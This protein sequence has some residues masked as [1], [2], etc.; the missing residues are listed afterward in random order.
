MKKLN[1]RIVI[2]IIL[3]FC[4]ISF[5]NVLSNPLPPKTVYGTSSR[6]DGAS[7]FDALVVGTASGYPNEYTNVVP[8]SMGA[9][10]FD[11]GGDTGI[12]WPDGTPFTV[13]I[14]MDGWIGSKNGV[15][16]TPATNV[17]HILLYPTGGPLNVD[18]GGVY[19]GFVNQQITFSG[20]VSGGSTPYN[21]FWSFGDDTWSN[22][23]NPK[24][25]YSEPGT[26]IVTL[27]V[28]DAASQTDSDTT[29]AVII[30]DTT[31][32][33]NANGPYTGMIGDEIQFNGDVIGGNPPYTWLWDFGDDEMSNEKDPIHVYNEID[34]YIVSLT[35]IDDLG[36]SDID[37]TS[38]LVSI[39]NEPPIE[40]LIS[41]ESEGK[42][43]DEYEY[44]FVTL[45][46]EDDNVYYYVDWGD[47]SSENWLG[48]YES[49]ESINLAHVWDEQGYYTIRAKA[50][51]N[52]G[53]ESDWTELEV[54]MP[55]SKIS[56]FQ[57]NISIEFRGGFGLTIIIKNNGDT[58]IPVLEFI[59]SFETPWMILGGESTTT[60]S[61]IPPGCKEKITTGFLFGF[62]QFNAT[63]NVL[64]IS[65]SRS[66][67][68]FGPFVILF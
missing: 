47:N 45:D 16:T 54:S 8:G 59:L 1:F 11:V 13:T 34:E 63:V 23:Q 67:F 64:D 22:E 50:K 36:F 57:N 35:V 41:G 28:I 56:S 2:L 52:Y 49:G 32:T 40:P 37:N 27:T 39:H 66:G 55:I 19:N 61:D 43:G 25:I 38:C 46:P 58:T 12:A 60:I 7:T 30:S 31:P 14:T 3:S 15:I 44:N 4:L 48:P 24:Y 6:T 18:A 42:A 10:T 65:K 29:N 68:M 21:W 9:W 20:S 53:F 62:G 5:N 17:G 51:D 26:Y 33:A